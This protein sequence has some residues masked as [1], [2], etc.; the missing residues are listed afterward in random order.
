LASFSTSLNFEQ[1]AFENLARYLNAKTK[2]PRSYD[3]P[4]FSPSLV[5]LGPRTPDN[6]SI[7]VPHPLKFHHENVL[8]R[9]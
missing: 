3:R 1:P 9:Q 2:L 7:K 5:K 6:C 8:N 4:M